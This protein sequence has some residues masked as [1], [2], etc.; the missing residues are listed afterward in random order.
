MRSSFQTTA[1]VLVGENILNS[2]LTPIFLCGVRYSFE[3]A[4]TL[5]DWVTEII[6]KTKEKIRLDGKR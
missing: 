6:S 3:A 2:V 5:A 4:Q 1:L